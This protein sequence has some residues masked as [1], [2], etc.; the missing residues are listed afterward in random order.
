MHVFSCKVV[1][2]K[3]Q[4][5][6]DNFYNNLTIKNSLHYVVVVQYLKTKE[7]LCIVVLNCKY[8]ANIIRPLK[9][10]KNPLVRAIL[11]SLH[12]S[13]SDYI[14]VVTFFDDVQVFSL[15]S[16]HVGNHI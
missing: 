13:Q 8:S 16:Y 11:P 10:Y 4:S 5:L 14:K 9:S 1:A 12:R 2:V 15:Y 6:L 7:I 3:F